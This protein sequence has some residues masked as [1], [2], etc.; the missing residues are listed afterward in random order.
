[1]ISVLVA[2]RAA[3]TADGLQLAYRSY[4]L[5]MLFVPLFVLAIAESARRRSAAPGASRVTAADRP[6]MERAGGDGA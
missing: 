1:S 2:S 4:A 3:T 6:A 5:I